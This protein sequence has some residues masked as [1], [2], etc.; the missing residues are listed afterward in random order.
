MHNHEVLV[1]AALLVFV[2]GLYSRVS[3]RWMITGPMVF[4]I[5]G[6]IASPLGFGLFT[7]YPNAEVVKLVAEITLMLILFIDAS[8]IKL[9]VLLHA[10]RRIPLRLLLIGLPLTMILGTG[11]GFLLFEDMDI[12]A[13]AL[14]ALIL[15]P[16]DAALGQAVV[17]SK[18]VPN[19]VR[20]YISV[21]SG[22]NDGMALPLVLVCLAA[23]GAD[24]GEH[25]G[26]WL[27]FMAKQL[28]IGP[29]VGI[30]VGWS[31]GKLIEHFSRRSWMDT[32]FQRLSSISIAILSYS[33][34]EWTG[35]NGFIAAFCAGLA[36]AI[37]T[38]EIRERIQ[39]FGEA[40]GTLFSLFVFLAFG[41]VMVPAALDYW[42]WSTLFY[43]IASLTIIRMIPVALSLIGTKLD[44][45]TI[46]FIGWFG[47][48]GIA[49]VLYL[50]IAVAA[51]GVDGN[52]SFLAV[53]VLTVLI[54][55][56]AHGVSAVPLTK[57]YGRKVSEED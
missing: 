40:E 9:D 49:S 57:M 52:E 39:E 54:S 41:L 20:N 31:G 14:V 46:A 43:A 37:P 15:S 30:F 32:T 51:I 38:P 29:V 34:A 44:W 55:V 24:A 48:R 22:L 25:Q 11:M 7:V 33:I 23:L 4:M 12:W 45:K 56:V 2:F 8:L 6:V 19:N 50:L 3:D 35:G 16:T 1:F 18:Q 17:K 27:A 36:L 13:I 21:E 28:T 5:V 53:I 47:P 26:G 10:P 42:T